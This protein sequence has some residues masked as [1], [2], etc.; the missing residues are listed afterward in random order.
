MELRISGGSA[1]RA[2]LDDLTTDAALAD[3][4]RSEVTARG[5][6]TRAAAVGRLERALAGLLPEDALRTRLADLCR[7][8]EADG[9]FSVAKGGVLHV[10]PVRAVVLEPKVHR[11]VSSLPTRV[12]GPQFPGTLEVDGVRREHHLASEHVGQLELALDS[13]GGVVLSVE[14]WAGLERSPHADDAWMSNL[15]QRLLWHPE[16]AG[17]L[18]RDGALDWAT[19]ELS[20]GG[21][22]WRLRS[23]APTRLWRARSAHGRWLFVWTAV[24]QTPAGADFISLSDDDAARS[25]FALARA[26]AVPVQARMEHEGEERRLFISEW[27]PRAEYR[28]LSTLGSCA[29]VDRVAV[30]T[31]AATRQPRVLSMLEERLGL[32]VISTEGGE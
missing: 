7:T 28:F 5:S 15:A 9:D 25:V 20:E 27:L 3:L 11:I 8:L 14:A 19:L 16:A 32:Q 30:W 10:S 12:L 4:L 24:E 22:R 18:E 1:Y 13:L 23:D 31:F 29:F 2:H 17:S 6:C 26:R 21:P